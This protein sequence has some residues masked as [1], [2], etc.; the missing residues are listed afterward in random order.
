MQLSAVVLPWGELE[1]NGQLL[2][3]LDAAMEAYVPVAHNKHDAGPLDALKV[4]STHA[5]Q[6][7]PLAPV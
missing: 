5:V 3:T 6:G 7:P 1:K 2:H 4:P